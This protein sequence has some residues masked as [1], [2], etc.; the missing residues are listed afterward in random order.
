MLTRSSHSFSLFLFLSLAV[1]LIF[2]NVFL[3]LTIAFYQLNRVLQKLRLKTRPI[4]SLPA[5]KLPAA[6]KQYV[7]SLQSQSERERF[8]EEA[9]LALVNAFTFACSAY[10]NA[11]LA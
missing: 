8:S 3:C 9:R 11:T 7:V 10:S 6:G 2:R 4:N 5:A 1:L